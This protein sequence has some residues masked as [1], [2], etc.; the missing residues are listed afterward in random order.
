MLSENLLILKEELQKTIR[1]ERK[2]WTVEGDDKGIP[3]WGIWGLFGELGTGRTQKILN[4]L[5]AYP[6]LSSVWFQKEQSWYPIG[7]YQNGLSQERALFINPSEETLFSTFFEVIESELF[8]VLILDFG[9]LMQNGYSLKVLR[10][11]HAK[12]EKHRRLCCLLIESDRVHDH[13]L[14]EKITT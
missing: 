9:K 2:T 10:K 13:W 4:F 8:D 1:P 5:V 6:Q 7:F 11:I 3:Q 12:S 14:F